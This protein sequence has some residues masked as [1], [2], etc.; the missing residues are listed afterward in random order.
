MDVV[1]QDA[2]PLV[3]VKISGTQ[4][5][6]VSDI[7]GEFIFKNMPVG[8][9]KLEFNHVS[10]K[11]CK[12]LKVVVQAQDTTILSIAL[13]SNVYNDDDMI[14]TSEYFAPVEDQPVSVTNFSRE[15]IRRAT[16]TGGDLNRIVTG[17]PSVA[18]VE[19]EQNSL[20]VRGG[21]PSENVYFV[22]GF[23]IGNINHFPIQGSS[24]GLYSM[25]NIEFVDN[26]NFYSGGYPAQYGN[27]MSSIIDIKLR[28]GSREGFRGQADINVGAISLF[29]EGPLPKRKGSYMLSGRRSSIS[30]AFDLVDEDLD[31]PEFRDFAGVLSYNLS[32]KAQLN[33]L[34]IYGYDFWD[35]GEHDAEVSG[36]DYF[37]NYKINRFNNGVS[38]NMFFN[39]Q[40]HSTLHFTF[41]YNNYEEDLY[42]V[43]SYQLPH[44]KHT[45]D[46]EFI[47]TNNNHMNLSEKHEIDYGFSAKYYYSNVDDFYGQMVNN[48]GHYVDSIAIQGKRDAFSYAAY[49]NHAWNLHQK[50][51]I[52]LGLRFDYHDYIGEYHLSPRMALEYNI[53]RKTSLSLAAGIYTQNLPLVLLIQ[54]NQFWDIKDPTAYHYIL[55]FRHFLN[56]STMFQIELYDKEY[57][58]CPTDRSQ[59]VIFILDQTIIDDVFLYNN[60]VESNANARSY[61]LEIMIQKKLSGKFYGMMCGSWFRSHYQDYRGVW[62]NRI[63]DNRYTTTLE[64]GYKPSKNW[65]FNL[66]WY[67]AGGRPYTPLVRMGISDYGIWDTRRINAERFPD[68]RCYTIRV[69][70]KFNFSSTNLA[71]YIMI[72]NATNEKKLIDIN[73]NE[74][75]N[76]PY[77]FNQWPRLYLFGVEF[78]F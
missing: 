7:N 12:Q 44:S 77:H 1:T 27:S 76:M 8:N 65:E 48:M 38:L 41:N 57:R 17:H 54:E 68:Y 62:H 4:F 43:S 30:M 28:E 74:H 13:F 45:I 29:A 51:K 46:R 35:V 11:S 60:M 63:Y 71:V 75:Q 56:E 15:E 5:S 9:Y 31:V 39:P 40:F 69:D 66:R 26:F 36:Y 6:T 52:N 3:T 61:G 53:N 22:N 78:E 24:G 58:H 25:L 23:E 72:W 37:G 67:Y 19:D 49:F 42:R 34:S 64:F 70:R 33:F 47:L 10:Y 20:A 16:G 73:F 32:K 14:V 50:L 21:S 2:I 18:K 59:S 55:G